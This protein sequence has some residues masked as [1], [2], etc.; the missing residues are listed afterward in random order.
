VSKIYSSFSSW[1]ILLSER[2]IF[3]WHVVSSIIILS[4][5]Q[6]PSENRQPI[7]PDCEAASLL[8]TAFGKKFKFQQF[9]LKWRWSIV[10]SR[11]SCYNNEDYIHQHPPHTMLTPAK[12]CRQK[13][14]TWNF[15][16]HIFSI[17]TACSSARMMRNSIG[18]NEYDIHIFTRIMTRKCCAPEQISFLK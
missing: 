17:P 13:M 6:L 3:T 15:Y 18:I 5:L 1:R 7:V 11:H 9:V 10:R 8:L 12:F 4:K 16:L 2:Q 14:F